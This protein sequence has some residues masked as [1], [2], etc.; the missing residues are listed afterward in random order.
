MRCCLCAASW[1]RG[2]CAVAGRGLASPLPI[3]L[4]KLAVAR[5]NIMREAASTAGPHDSVPQ[6]STDGTARY[7]T[8]GS[9]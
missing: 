1:L 7:V 2:G 8:M 3:Y 6:A 5:G 4:G 9:L